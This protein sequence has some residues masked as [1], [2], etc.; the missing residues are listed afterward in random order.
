MALSIKLQEKI[1]K[2]AKE[3]KLVWM[4]APRG[5]RG[6]VWIGF[7]TKI[8]PIQSYYYLRFGSVLDD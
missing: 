2:V 4:V 7:E 5:A 8:H 3:K 1:N 6:S